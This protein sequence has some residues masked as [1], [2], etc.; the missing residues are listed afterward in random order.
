ML[1]LI[2]TQEN[3]NS[4]TI[5]IQDPDGS[6]RCDVHVEIKDNRVTLYLTDNVKDRDSDEVSFTK[7]L[8]QREPAEDRVAA[9]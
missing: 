6:L 7:E 3:N 9:T 8:M 4:G 1:H 2:A 5:Q